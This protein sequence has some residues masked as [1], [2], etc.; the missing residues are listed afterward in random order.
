[1]QLANFGDKTEGNICKRQTTYL[2]FVESDSGTKVKINYKN[3]KEYLIENGPF[4][5]V[6]VANE[7]PLLEEHENYSSAI[8]ISSSSLDS[9]TITNEMSEEIQEHYQGWRT[10]DSYCNGGYGVER[11]IREGSGLIYEGPPSGAEVVKRVL[12]RHDL[13]FTVPGEGKLNGKKFNVLLLGGNYVVAEEF[14]VEENE[15]Y[16]G[17]STRTEKE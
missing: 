13:R 4:K 15:T 2:V 1:M 17:K 8:Y 9:E 16:Q 11:I 14:S 3:K 7:H 5:G 6:L 12:E 10:I